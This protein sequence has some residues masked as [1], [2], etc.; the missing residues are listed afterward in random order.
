M[1]DIATVII[2]DF[3]PVS[4]SPFIYSSWRNSLFYGSGRKNEA[5]ETARFFFR[6][7]TKKIRRILE[8]PETRVRVACTEDRPNVIVGYS[9]S[10]RAHLEWI[11]VKVDFRGEGIASLLF[12]KAI[13]T[14]TPDFTRI[15]IEIFKKKNLKFKEN[16]DERED[17]ERDGKR[18]ET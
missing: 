11:Y 16:S 7:Q 1:T 12:P 17:E 14:V 15:G 6:Q 9:V 18:N 8:N 10:T 13:E 3:D 4:D 2:R 5:N